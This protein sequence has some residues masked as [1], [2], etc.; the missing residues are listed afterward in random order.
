MNLPEGFD[1]N[2]PDDQLVELMVNSGRYDPDE[3]ADIVAMLRSGEIT[4]E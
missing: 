2:L 3:A 4:L 1:L